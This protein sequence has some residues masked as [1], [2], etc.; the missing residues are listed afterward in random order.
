MCIRDSEQLGQRLQA[1]VE[2]VLCDEDLPVRMVR[3]GSLFWFSFDKG[4]PPRRADQIPSS[5]AEPYA[6]FFHAC[7]KRG[8]HLA[9]SAYEVG[10]LSTAHTEADIDRAVDVF[11]TSLRE[12]LA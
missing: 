3:V 1:G 2:K 10:F 4:E 7:L 8:V 5:C 12:A 9:P 11:T 6:K